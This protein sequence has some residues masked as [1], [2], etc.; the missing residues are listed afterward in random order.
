MKKI[1]EFLIKKPI[2]VSALILLQL[3]IIYALI[4]RMSVQWTEF[5][6]ILQALNV[7]LVIYIINKNDNPSYKIAWIVFIL[8]VLQ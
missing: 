3:G 5:Y 1:I 8:G 4:F 2:S 6:F 7:L